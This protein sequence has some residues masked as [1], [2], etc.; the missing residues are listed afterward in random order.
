M[1]KAGRSSVKGNYLMTVVNGGDARQSQ[2]YHERFFVP[3]SHIFSILPV[4]I[5][6]TFNVKISSSDYTRENERESRN[7]INRRCRQR[8]TK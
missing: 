4:S 7:E 3:L 2:L 6:T 5:F 1:E 8:M